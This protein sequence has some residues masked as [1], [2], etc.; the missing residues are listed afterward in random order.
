MAANTSTGVPDTVATP[1][2]S[3]VRIEG[4]GVVPGTRGEKIESRMPFLAGRS[5]TGTDRETARWA[6]ARSSG[7]EL[8][9]LFLFVTETAPR[10]PTDHVSTRDRGRP[11]RHADR[12]RTP[13]PCGTPGSDRA[14]APPRAPREHPRPSRRAWVREQASSATPR[15]PTPRQDRAHTPRSRRA[16]LHAPRSTPRRPAQASEATIRRRVGARRSLRP[17]RRSRRSR[18]PGSARAG[19]IP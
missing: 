13:E 7:R 10:L 9:L 2:A 16:L 8:F 11:S 5:E 15:K 6:T 3:D 18:P 1:R 19:T 17:R 14:G 12:P 4:I